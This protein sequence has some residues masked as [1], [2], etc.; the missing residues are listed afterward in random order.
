[1][2]YEVITHLDL[3]DYLIFKAGQRGFKLLLTPII[4]YNANWP[5]NMAATAQATGFSNHFEKS[6]LGTSEK[7][8]AAQ[9]NY[10]EQLLNHLIV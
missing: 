5:E 2:L 4:T 1:M 7:A 8:I 9:S 10:I 3:L 6:E